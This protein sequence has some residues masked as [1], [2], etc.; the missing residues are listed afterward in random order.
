MIPQSQNQNLLFFIIEFVIFC[1][2]NQGSS[3]KKKMANFKA[4]RKIVIAYNFTN[5]CNIKSYPV[6]STTTDA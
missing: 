1:K 2:R 4:P 5:E 3:Q 6:I